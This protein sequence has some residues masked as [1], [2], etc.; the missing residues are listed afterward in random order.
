MTARAGAENA[1]KAPARAN[2]TAGN[3]RREGDRLIKLRVVRVAVLRGVG[4]CIGSFFLFSRSVNRGNCKPAKRQG[5]PGENNRWL[6]SG[7]S[8]RRMCVHVRR[9]PAHLL[10][11]RD[12]LCPTDSE[13]TRHHS[14]VAFGFPTGE[15]CAQAARKPARPAKRL[16]AVSFYFDTEKIRAFRKAAITAIPNQAE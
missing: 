15:I 10:K 16:V 6:D 12:Y 3:R 7:Y 4:R 1:N 5:L 11:M 2:T 14:S 9:C 8:V 13:A